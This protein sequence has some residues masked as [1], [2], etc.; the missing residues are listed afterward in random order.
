MLFRVPPYQPES[1]LLP[2]RAGLLVLDRRHGTVL[3]RVG[4]SHGFA[5]K[6]L[7]VNGTLYAFQTVG[8]FYALGIY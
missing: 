5:A 3:R 7:F 6:P 4:D 8:R 2:T 1:L